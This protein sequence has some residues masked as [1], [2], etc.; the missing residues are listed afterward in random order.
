MPKEVGYNKE[1]KEWMIPS[2]SYGISANDA[3]DVLV[4]GME[5]KS[6]KTLYKA[7]LAVLKEKKKAINA[8][9]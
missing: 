9:T 1:P 7:A 6:N 4:T 3:A 8:L 5:I 2:R